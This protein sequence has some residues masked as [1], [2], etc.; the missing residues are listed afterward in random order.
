MPYLPGV[1]FWNPCT[2]N[3]AE[4]YR[5]TR[6]TARCND[7]PEAETVRIAKWYFRDLS[8]VLFLFRNPLPALADPDYEYQEIYRVGH[9]FGHW[10]ETFFLYRALPRNSSKK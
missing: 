1:R 9:A 3:Y 10:Q 7:L 4:Y 8:R 5:L 2:G 6:E